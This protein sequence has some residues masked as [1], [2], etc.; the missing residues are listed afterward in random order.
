MAANDNWKS[1]IRF[2]NIDD[3]FTTQDERDNGMIKTLNIADI[4]PFQGHTFKVNDDAKMYELVESIQNNG[5]VN[6]VIVFTNE[7]GRYEMISGHRRMRA[8]ELAGMETIPAVVKKLNRD[9]ATIIMVETNLQSRDVILPSEKAYSYKAMYD[10]V[11]RQGKRTDLT[12]SPVET[13]L[14]NQRADKELENVL[15]ESRAQIQRYIAITRLIPELMQLV[16]NG[17]LKEPNTL[18]MAIR[19]AVE[20]SQISTELQKLIYAYCEANEITPSLAQAI[21]LKKMFKDCELDEETIEDVLSVE[22]PNQKNSKLVIKEPGI[23]KY[24]GNLSDDE[25]IDKIGKALEM[26]ERRMEKERSS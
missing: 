26:Y 10:A 18:Q 22:K 24:K 1:N 6:P 17:A 7:D 13:K 3:L 20:L 19:P 11:K 23:L 9:E 21:S 14:K 2:D 15:N 5:V 4:I 12:S 25:F 16:D 8:S